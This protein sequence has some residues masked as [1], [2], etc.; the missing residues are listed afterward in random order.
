MLAHLIF[1]ALMA[2]LAAGPSDVKLAVAPDRVTIRVVQAG[3]GYKKEELD[4]RRGPHGFSDGTRA[5]D[6][7]ALR[8]LAGAATAAP[9]ASLDIRTLPVD[10]QALRRHAEAAAQHM[11]PQTRAWFIARVCDPSQLPQ[12]ATSL[13]NSEHTD[14][15]PSVTVEL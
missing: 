5:V 1:V 12:L 2:D 8:A 14:D 13:I 10:P 9:R 3:W 6:E 7:R 4:I 15:Y 11:P